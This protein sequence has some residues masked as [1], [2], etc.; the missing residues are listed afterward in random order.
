MPVIGRE[1]VFKAKNMH[2]AYAKGIYMLETNVWDL[3]V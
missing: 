2:P 3:E 1:Y